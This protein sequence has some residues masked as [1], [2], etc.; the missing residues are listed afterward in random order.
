MQFL[1]GLM[2]VISLHSGD[3]LV[4]LAFVLQTTVDSYIMNKGCSFHCV[5]FLFVMSRSMNSS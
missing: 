4:L 2:F 3:H 1:A 5:N